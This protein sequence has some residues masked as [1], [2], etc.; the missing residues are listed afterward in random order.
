[1]FSR[2]PLARHAWCGMLGVV[3]DPVDARVRGDLDCGPPMKPQGQPSLLLRKRHG[4][5]L[6]ARYPR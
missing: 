1:M 6:T 3:G 4:A 5:A 2:K